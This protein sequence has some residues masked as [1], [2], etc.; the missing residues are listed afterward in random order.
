MENMYRRE[1]Q[2][3]LLESS[4]SDYRK[5]KDEEMSYKQR[6][7]FELKMKFERDLKEESEEKRRRREMQEY[8]GECLK[9][10]I[11]MDKAK[12]MVEEE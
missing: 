4:Y 6:E 12:K 2:Q 3:K 9:N 8:N 10:Q 5:R 11:T 1:K 7:E